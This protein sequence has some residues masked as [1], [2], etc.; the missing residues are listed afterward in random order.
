MPKDRA[1]KVEFSDDGFQK[2]VRGGEATFRAG[3]TIE[4]LHKG[5]VFPMGR[6]RL[7]DMKQRARHVRLTFP[8]GPVALCEV[9]I[10]RAR[11][12]EARFGPSLL[13]DLDG[14]GQ[15][16][17]AITTDTGE[18]VV[19]GQD[20]RKRWGKKFAGPV[21]CLRAGG[22]VGTAHPTCL[23]VGTWEARLYCFAADGRQ[24]WMTDFT[25]LGGD[26]PVPFSIALTQLGADGKRGIIVGNY[27]R[28]SF[29]SPDGKLLSHTFGYGAFEALSLTDGLDL[30]GDGVED[31][32]V[33]NV[34]AT[35]SVVDG[36]KRK[37][38]RSIGCP[39]GE[40]LALRRWS[41]GADPSVLVASDNGLGVLR[42]VSGNYD[43]QKT[44]SP[45]SCLAVADV[46][47]DGQDEI[48]VG[49]RDGWLLVLSGKGEVKRK[50]LIGDEVRSVVALPSRRLW[51][52]TGTDIR[53]MDKH[54]STLARFDCIAQRLEA[55][56][57]DLVLILGADGLVTVIRD[58]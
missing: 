17:A 4:P 54:L 52:A 10:R 25:P 27:A 50:V 11:G 21:T 29:V 43:W 37:A 49:K 14:D 15:E 34:W 8:P 2:D 36:A 47:E 9:F 22:L 1:L 31:A 30:T 12:T 51:I 32:L 13:A 7:A 45:M 46:D 6:W 16:E 33:Y 39:R 35:L 56:G 23:L 41:D 24:E 55:M 48:V 38:E 5:T 20:G 42:P 18:L 3:F 44:L 40:G 57:K 53:V 26:L 28:V 58:A 19:L